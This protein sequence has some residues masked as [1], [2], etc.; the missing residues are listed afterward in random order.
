MAEVTELNDKSETKTV[1]PFKKPAPKSMFG[2]IRQALKR[3]GKYKSGKK[4]EF[5]RMDKILIAA[6]SVV[7][8]GGI[9]FC[10]VMLILMTS[11]T[12]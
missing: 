3:S 10:L 6:T 4:S 12:Y 1:K 11:I 7:A 2:N 5:S 9:V 8:F